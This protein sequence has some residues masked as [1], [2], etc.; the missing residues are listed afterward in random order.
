MSDSKKKDSPWSISNLKRLAFESTIVRIVEVVLLAIAAPLCAWF[1]LPGLFNRTA[2]ETK[3]PVVIVQNEEQIQSEA[4]FKEAPTAENSIAFQR[5]PKTMGL[6]SSF[7][8]Y[9]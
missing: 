6:R 9:A 2:E 5:L 3:H 8:V 7:E 1:G 4:A